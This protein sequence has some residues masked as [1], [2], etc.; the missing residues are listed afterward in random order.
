MDFIIIFPQ[1]CEKKGSKLNNLKCTI[2]K[3]TW[4]IYSSEWINF[5]LKIYNFLTKINVDSIAKNDL[6][7]QSHLL[8]LKYTMKIMTN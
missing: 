1:F 7:L 5:G 3:S 4:S 8:Q 6:N 2:Y